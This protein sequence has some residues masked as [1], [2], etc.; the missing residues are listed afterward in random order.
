MA[1][2]SSL[3]LSLGKAFNTLAQHDSHNT[4]LIS[5]AARNDSF[6]MRAIALLTL[7]FLPSTL[8]SVSYSYKRPFPLY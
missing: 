8:V 5:Q 4:L 6:D 3:S 1:D 2:I 7:V